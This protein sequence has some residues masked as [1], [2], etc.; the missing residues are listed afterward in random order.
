[1][2]DLVV[3]K[4]GCLQIATPRIDQ[5]FALQDAMMSMPTELQLDFNSGL[6]HTF[7]EGTYARE[8]SMP[9]DMVIIGKIHRHSHIN[10]VSK[11]KCMVFT[12]EGMKLID[13]TD[14]PVTFSSV[15]GTKRVVYMLEDTVWTTIHLTEETDL[16]K[17]EAE[18]IIDEKE[19]KEQLDM[20]KITTEILT[21][22]AIID[23][24][25]IDMVGC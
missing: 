4:N 15:A 14:H 17:I 21:Y 7:S 20:N 5:I 11:G 6:K 16:D 25:N 18:I 24:K 12:T 9:K 1:M 19:Y 10:I 2:T 22:K 3:D 13:A 8:L 23:A